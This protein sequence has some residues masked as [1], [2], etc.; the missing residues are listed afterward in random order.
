MNNNFISLEIERIGKRIVATIDSCTTQD[1]SKPMFR[2]FD[3]GTKRI[4]FL[5]DKIKKN[6]V[7]NAKQ[8]EVDFKNLFNN[9]ANKVKVKASELK[10]GNRSNN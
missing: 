9:L 1:H 7:L 3:L 2:Y 10:N 8:L 4:E 6:D 5:I